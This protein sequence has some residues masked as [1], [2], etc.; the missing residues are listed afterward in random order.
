MQEERAAAAREYLSARVA[1][2]ADKGEVRQGGTGK[3]GCKAG[4][5]TGDS[6]RVIDLLRCHALPVPLVQLAQTHA[7]LCNWLRPC[8]RLRSL[9]W[10]PSCACLW[11]MCGRGCSAKR[12]PRSAARQMCVGAWLLCCW[13]TIAFSAQPAI[14]PASAFLLC[15]GTQQ[16]PWHIPGPPLPVPQVAASRAA[17]EKLAS[18]KS[19]FYACWP[20]LAAAVAAPEYGGRGPAALR[21][22]AGMVMADDNH[23]RCAE[24]LLKVLQSDCDDVM[25]MVR[26]AV[27]AMHAVRAVRAVTPCMR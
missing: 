18:G 22:T 17:L 25:E 1:A 20:S 19:V 14:P 9:L 23:K 6:N 10:W 13:P 7:C 8:R 27:H 15:M 5:N 3:G 26:R 12:R 4:S 24:L 21:G 16:V 11:W 2:A